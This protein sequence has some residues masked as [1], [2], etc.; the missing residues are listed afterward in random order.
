MSGPEEILKGQT[1]EQFNR[2]GP[3]AQIF[4]TPIFQHCSLS[5]FSYSIWQG[6]LLGTVDEWLTILIKRIYNIGLPGWKLLQTYQLKSTN[7]LPFLP[8]NR[9]I[10]FNRGLNWRLCNAIVNLRLKSGFNV[11]LISTEDGVTGT[12]GVMGG[13]GEDRLNRMTL[14]EW[15]RDVIPQVRWCISKRAVGD[16]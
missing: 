4:A 7:R 15:R 13:E 8:R 12:E 2:E 16:L 11:R 9:V 1:Y 5:T 10:G 14:M 6:D 3:R